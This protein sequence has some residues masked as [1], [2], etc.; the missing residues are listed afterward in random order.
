MNILSFLYCIIVLYFY[1]DRTSTTVFH[2][3]LINLSTYPSIV[4]NTA[5]RFS[6]R[7]QIA[8]FRKVKLG[9]E[10]SSGGRGRSGLAIVWGGA[11]AF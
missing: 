4:E 2:H 3:Y 11:T 10:R 1:Y 8:L 7:L 5:R 6:L 9:H